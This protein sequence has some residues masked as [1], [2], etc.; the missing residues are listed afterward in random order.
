[1]NF[2]TIKDVLRVGN[3]L[4]NGTNFQC[5]KCKKTGEMTHQA[6]PSKD[7][8]HGFDYCCGHCGA[9]QLKEKAND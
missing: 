6:L 2:Y 4:D 9:W 1:M 3:L 5:N 8:K 7:F